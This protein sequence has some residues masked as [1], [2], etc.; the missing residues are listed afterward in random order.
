M[1]SPVLHYLFQSL[2][3]S[4]RGEN[5]GEAL[6]PVTLHE[7]NITVAANKNSGPN[8]ME[9]SKNIACIITPQG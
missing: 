9:L 2:F 5:V 1:L 4:N 3:T 8:T 7:K 6:Y